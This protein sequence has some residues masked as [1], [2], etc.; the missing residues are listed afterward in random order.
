[1][2]DPCSY[3]RKCTPGSLNKYEDWKAEAC[4]GKL[5]DSRKASVARAGEDV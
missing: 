1:M 2:S 3:W 5:R 4:I